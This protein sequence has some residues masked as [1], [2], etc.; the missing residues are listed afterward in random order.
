MPFACFICRGDFSEPVVTLCGHYFCNGCA[1]K[2]FKA[3]N[4]RCA[5]CD[6]QTFGVYNKAR[7]LIKH[8]EQKNKAGGSLEVKSGSSLG[9]SR[10]Q[11]TAGRWETV[12]KDG[13]FE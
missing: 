7:K 10:S 3:G 11:A 1:V 9:Y 5:A 13:P 6:K 8:L 2:R 4:T 12:D